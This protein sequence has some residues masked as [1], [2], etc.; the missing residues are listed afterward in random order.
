MIAHVALQRVSLAVFSSLVHQLGFTLFA[1]L[2]K[3]IFPVHRPFDPAIMIKTI[4][5][6]TFPIN[7]ATFKP[8]I[9]TL[10]QPEESVASAGPQ[11]SECKPKTSEQHVAHPGNYKSYIACWF[12]SPILLCRRPR[13]SLVEYDQP[14]EIESSFNH[15]S[16]FLGS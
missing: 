11:E 16:F 7:P 14:T 3:H 15:N 9:I 4:R 2:K 6:T 10:I 5:N 8:Q 1:L 13:M 12:Q